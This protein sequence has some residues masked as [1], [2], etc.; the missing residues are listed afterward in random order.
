MPTDTGTTITRGNWMQ[1]FFTLLGYEVGQSNA[2][3]INDKS[4]AVSHRAGN[5]DGFPIHIIGF[6][7]SLD[8]RVENGVRLS[9]HAL[10]QEYINNTEYL[11]GYI[12]NGLQLRIL[13][14]ATHL[15][16]LS[17]LE[18][19]L[20][21]MM[22]EGHFNEFALLYRLLHATRIANSKD[23]SADSI[24]EFYHNFH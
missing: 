18:F 4:Y 22:E 6:N 24:L 15:S 16:K 9:P 10:M 20:E 19:N 7:Q 14:D 23:E 13:R 17:Y 12:T 1:H 8:K 21:Q 5:K 11:Y 3:I 2:E